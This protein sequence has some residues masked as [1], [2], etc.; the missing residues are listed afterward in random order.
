MGTR[1]GGERRPGSR[2]LAV[3]EP[4]SGCRSPWRK[5]RAIG[6]HYTMRIS[7]I[8]RAKWPQPSHCSRKTRA[9][10]GAGKGSS[11]SWREAWFGAGLSS[12]LGLG[13]SSV[14]EVGR[15]TQPPTARLG[16]F[17]ERLRR[18]RPW[19]GGGGCCSLLFPGPGLELLWEVRAACPCGCGISLDRQPLQD[20]LQASRVLREG[21]H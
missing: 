20:I 4:P 12:H 18:P 10:A 21:T 7:D 15:G 16:P 5:L 9:G 6:I 2:L 11:Q 1:G 13:S 3:L 17:A 19:G 8:D 14:R